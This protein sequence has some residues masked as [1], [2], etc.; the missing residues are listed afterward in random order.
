MDVDRVLKLIS[1]LSLKTADRVS[2]LFGPQRAIVFAG[3]VEAWVE[4]QGQLKTVQELL[5]IPGVGEKEAESLMEW[6]HLVVEEKKAAKRVVRLDK[7]QRSGNMRIRYNQT[8]T[9]V[10]GMTKDRSMYRWRFDRQIRGMGLMSAILEAELGQQLP[11]SASP[12]L[13]VTSKP[14]DDPIDDFIEVKVE[15]PLEVINHL[16]ENKLV[17]SQGKWIWN[18]AHPGWDYMEAALPN[19]IEATAY[20]GGLNAPTVPGGII[21]N[22]QVV[23]RNI[24]TS[25]GIN[26]QCDGSG[27]IHPKHQLIKN[28]ERPGGRAFTIQIRGINRKGTFVKG[29]LV[30]DERCVEWVTSSV[31]PSTDEEMDA[32]MVEANAL[33]W[34]EVET[35]T[36]VNAIQF[37]VPQVWIDWRQV[38]G[39][40]KPNP[41]GTPAQKKSH[42]LMTSNQQVCSLLNI[43]V[44]NVWDK[45]G[46]LDW[47]F[48]VLENFQTTDENKGFVTEF[49]EEAYQEL[50]EQGVDGLAAR[51]AKDSPAAAL[52]VR[53][54]TALNVREREKALLAGKDASEAKQYSPLAIPWLHRAVKERLQR[55]LWHFAQ[56][57]GMASPRFVACIDA[58]VPPG[59]VVLPGFRPG[60]TLAVF[61][62][63]VVLSQVLNTV[64][65]MEPLP[66]HLVD[67]AI[68][69][70]TIYMNPH[71]ITARLMGD[72][73]GDTVGVSSDK[74]VLKLFSQLVDDGVYA[75]EP[76]GNKLDIPTNSKEGW[77]YMARDQKGP[78]G[79]ITMVRSRLLAV[80][81]ILG[82]RSSSVSIQEAIDKGKRHVIWSDYKCGTDESY[83]YTGDDGYTRFVSPVDP[84]HSPKIMGDLEM[85]DMYRW[86]N[87]RNKEYGGPDQPKLALGWKQW[88]QDKRVRPDKW[89]ECVNYA[90]GWNGGNLVH[91]SSDAA[92]KLW[93]KIERKF[94]LN[95]EPIQMHE[96]LPDLIKEKHPGFQQVD[97]SM[98]WDTYLKGIRKEVGIG[99]LAVEYKKAYAKSDESERFRAFDTA[100][101]KL[102]LHLKKMWETDRERAMRLSQQAWW[103]ETKHARQFDKSEKGNINYAYHLVAWEGSPILAM[104]GMKTGDESCSYLKYKLEDD[105]VGEAL[106]GDNP[107]LKLNELLVTWKSKKFPDKTINQL[108]LEFEPRPVEIVD[109]PHCL[110]RLQNT[111]VRKIRADR[112]RKEHQWFC[113]TTEVLNEYHHAVEQLEWED[114][115]WASAEYIDPFGE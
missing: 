103:M 37:L 39:K 57:A 20:N 10:W 27:R 56:G 83:W 112:T 38:K 3:S 92:L 72:D 17:V 23:I 77:T 24:T 91:H 90:H 28:L 78:V 101:E 55:I 6:A 68:V 66:H 42:Q 53:F 69:P 18:A 106:K 26:A 4:Q 47:C 52:A 76:T 96:M 104:L 43:G 35:E 48:E 58:A 74:R 97:R 105:L 99:D 31:V 14:P 36:E 64:E 19:A 81:D 41:K 75:I 88:G 79:P 46:T 1:G 84:L 67:G 16:H 33:D 108:H 2:E 95:F 29:I 107:F 7:A 45:P 49:L 85:T 61:R 59:Y 114:P 70:F 98:D 32:A 5:T 80:G 34:R 63:P 21:L 13:A 54:V 15:L 89:T 40:L 111:L 93:R 50:E 8:P 25:E 86:A 102:H 44:I 113:D 110:D 87:K 94:I 62:I 12:M 100:T 9:W 115:N 51:I 60:T 71:D 82:A 30:P 73:D 11:P 65:V 22:C 109:C